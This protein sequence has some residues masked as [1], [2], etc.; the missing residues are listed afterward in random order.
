VKKDRLIPLGLACRNFYLFDSK[1]L[2][3]LLV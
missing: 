3:I 2:K 1:V